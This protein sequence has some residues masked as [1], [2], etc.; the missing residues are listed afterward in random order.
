MICL[1]G[2]YKQMVNI[3]EYIFHHEPNYKYQYQLGLLKCVNASF[4]RHQGRR[5]LALM[6]PNH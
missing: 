6:K 5:H 2:P 4:V 1:D 3:P